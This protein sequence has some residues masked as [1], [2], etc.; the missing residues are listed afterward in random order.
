MHKCHVSLVVNSCCSGSIEEGEFRQKCDKP[1]G[2]DCTFGE[3]ASGGNW[4]GGS[5]YTSGTDHHHHHPLSLV[6]ATERT[7]R[8]VRLNT[9]GSVSSSANTN[10]LSITC[11]SHL[12]RT[13]Q[14]HL[15]QRPRRWLWALRQ[16][17]WTM[18][19]ALSHWWY[20]LQ[21]GWVRA[22]FQSE[23]LDP[24]CGRSN[25]GPLK[26]ERWN[27][28]SVLIHKNTSQTTRQNTDYWKYNSI[29]HKMHHNECT[30]TTQRNLHWTFQ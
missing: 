4:V 16:D 20:S 10:E 15:H 23:F 22:F 8:N 3:V 17:H 21:T 11:N 12:K 27:S 28:F 14:H 25:Q 30:V 26:W 5:S 9:T 2:D 24:I 18:A 1:V 6:T 7:T 19:L 29:H 13:S